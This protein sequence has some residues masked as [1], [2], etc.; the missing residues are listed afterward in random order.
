MGEAPRAA[1]QI[2]CLIDSSKS[3]ANL[4]SEKT[5]VLQEIGRQAEKNLEDLWKGH[6]W[7]VCNVCTDSPSGSACHFDKGE[8]PLKSS[9]ERCRDNLLVIPQIQK[10]P[11]PKSP[12][13]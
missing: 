5:D 9:E 10:R 7:V 1:G 3:E 12:S 11:M 2:P 13:L 6:L 8:F 4:F